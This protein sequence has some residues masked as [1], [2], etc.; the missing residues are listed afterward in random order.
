VVQDEP[1]EADE[2]TGYEDPRS[3]VVDL[4]CR[5]ASEDFL[6]ECARLV[7]DAAGGVRVADEEEF[8]KA[9]AM[10][11][12]G[13]RLRIQVSN[14]RFS[15]VR[16]VIDAGRPLAGVKVLSAYPGMPVVPDGSRFRVRVPPRGTVVLEAQ[17]SWL[18][19]AARASD[20]RAASGNRE[21]AT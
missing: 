2:P 10:E 7:R 1:R 12:R 14:D 19:D 8:V 9:W 16:T 18:P 6:R 13:G 15:Y 3:F 5:D 20:A 4:P 21:G 11:E 17:V